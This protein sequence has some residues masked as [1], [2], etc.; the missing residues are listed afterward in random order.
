[1]ATRGLSRGGYVAIHGPLALGALRHLCDAR[2]EPGAVGVDERGLL[3]LR[4]ALSADRHRGL[5]P[6]RGRHREEELELRLRAGV[7]RL[8]ARLDL[9]TD[10]RTDGLTR[11]E[12]LPWRPCSPTLPQVSTELDVAL[13]LELRSAAQRRQVHHAR[14]PG[15]LMAPEEVFARQPRGRR[16]E[17]NGDD[18]GS[19]TVCGR[20][21]RLG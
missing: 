11:R 15:R 1:M 9:V 17:G 18:R 13:D 7:A 20:G 19:R 8:D 6:R 12:P 2:I 16:N 14:I 10:A 4:E 5:F 21:N 3:L